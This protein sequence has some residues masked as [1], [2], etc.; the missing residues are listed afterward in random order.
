MLVL[1]VALVC[2]DE[3]EVDAFG[4]S[5]PSDRQLQHLPTTPTSAMPSDGDTHATND[6]DRYDNRL[7]QWSVT[8][9]NMLAPTDGM[10][11]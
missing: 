9:S 3:V 1:L 10:V 2:V 6:R 4:T 7:P 11:A 8:Y 5:L